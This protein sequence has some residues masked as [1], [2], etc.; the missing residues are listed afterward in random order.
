MTD[1][2]RDHGRLH[3]DPRRTRRR[4]VVWLAAAVL[5]L[6]TS[7][8]RLFAAP[9]PDA[10][11]FRLGDAARPFGWSTVVGDFNRDGRPDVAVADHVTRRPGGYTYRLEFSISGLPPQDATFESSHD[12]VAISVADVDGDDDFDIIVTAPLSGE[13]LAVW[14][15]DGHGRFSSAGAQRVPP[16]VRP[17]GSFGAPGAPDAGAVEEIAP[18]V[19]DARI[20][21]GIVAA[22]AGP[23]RASSAILPDR[24]VDSAFLS[25]RTGPRAP[26]AFLPTNSRNG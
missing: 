12:A 3:P 1:S 21:A 17:V 13:T 8:P 19:L 9:V 2:V 4:E 14:L 10:P 15:N 7:A 18:L 20:P 22:R 26:P 5:L 16:V 23:D 6:A 11:R 24:C 25:S